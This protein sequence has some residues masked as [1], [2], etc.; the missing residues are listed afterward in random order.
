MDHC[1]ENPSERSLKAALR[2]AREQSLARPGGRLEKAQPTMLGMVVAGLLVFSFLST[3][4]LEPVTYLRSQSIHWI[5]LLLSVFAGV[6]FIQGRRAAALDR[7]DRAEFKGKTLN[8]L[9]ALG[10]AGVRLPDLE[11][12]MRQA[13]EEIV[14]KEPSVRTL[15]EGK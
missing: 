2:L 3:S 5:A 7:E 13:Y 15:L 1:A 4:R 10:E 9:R 11:V 12:P 14:R 8:T 6:S